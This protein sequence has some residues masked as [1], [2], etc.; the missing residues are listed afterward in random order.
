MGF[1]IWKAC[2]RGWERSLGQGAARLHMCVHV[3]VRVYIYTYTHV[4]IHIYIYLY[5]YM[6][7]F[8]C[9][10]INVC[11]ERAMYTYGEKQAEWGTSYNP[12]LRLP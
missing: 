9:M 6:C 2:S 5:I 8:M 3:F 12:M 10:C 11:V 4:Y 1:A 7:V